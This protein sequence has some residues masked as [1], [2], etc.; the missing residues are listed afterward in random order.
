VFFFFQAKAQLFLE[1]IQ[2]LVQGL[3]EGVLGVFFQSL[4][5]EHQLAEAG[6][7]LAVE[8]DEHHGL[9]DVHDAIQ[10]RRQAGLFLHQVVNQVVNGCE[11]FGWLLIGSVFPHAIVG[12]WGC[13]DFLARLGPTV[14]DA[15]GRMAAFDGKILT[16]GAIDASRPTFH[17]FG[18]RQH[19]PT[20]MLPTTRRVATT[21][22]PL[23]ALPPI[24]INVLTFPRCIHKNHPPLFRR[25]ALV[26]CVAP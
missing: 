8:G 20:T 5:V 15:T 17:G 19:T 4:F 24:L 14:S 10:K 3:L 16:W 22:S 13:P 1:L 2:N 11:Y 12:S 25:N 26:K 21:D 9:S 7:V 18:L 6:G 23:S